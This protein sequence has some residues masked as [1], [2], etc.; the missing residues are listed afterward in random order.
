MVYNRVF[1][2]SKES[3]TILHRNAERILR[4]SLNEYHPFNGHLAEIRNAG[5]FHCHAR[6]LNGMR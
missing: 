5:N 1:Y 2:H 4:L 6:D 3:A